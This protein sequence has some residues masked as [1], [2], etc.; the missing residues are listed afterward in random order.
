MTGVDEFVVIGS[1]AILGSLEQPPESMLQSLKVDIYRCA[2]RGRRTSSTARSG[3]GSQ[4]HVAFGYY[5]PRR[6]A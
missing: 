2:I 6:R 3:T 5:R 1:L 4:F